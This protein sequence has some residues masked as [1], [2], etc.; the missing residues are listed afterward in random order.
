MDLKSCVTVMVQ[1]GPKQGLK[2][3]S[4]FVIGLTFVAGMTCY[5]DIHIETQDFEFAHQ[6]DQQRQHTHPPQHHFFMPQMR[7]AE[8]THQ[9]ASCEVFER[10]QKTPSLSTEKHS[11]K[12]SNAK[13]RWCHHT[14]RSN[15]CRPSCLSQSAP[16]PRPNQTPACGGQSSESEAPNPKGSSSSNPLRPEPLPGSQPLNLRYY[17]R[18]WVLPPRINL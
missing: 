16:K 15:T 3:D 14:N 7:Q 11:T 17:C 9:Q 1:T 2:G 10:Q 4:I 8:L 6:Q 12:Q 18:F 5:R 13:T